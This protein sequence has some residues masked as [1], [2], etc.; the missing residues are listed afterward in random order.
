MAKKKSGYKYKM[1]KPE[2][3]DALKGMTEEE[4]QAEFVKATKNENAAKK[5]RK[6]DND[7]VELSEKIKS[8]RQENTPKKVSEL[9]EEIMVYV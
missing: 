5:A 8:H 3:Y 1:L 4:L 2:D 6:E 9:Q 7:I